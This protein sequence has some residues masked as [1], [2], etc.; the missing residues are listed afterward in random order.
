VA[1][2][3]VATETFGWMQRH[4]GN[5]FSRILSRPGYELQRVAGTREPSADELAVARA[6]LDA[7]LDLEGRSRP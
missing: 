7:V 3:G 4:R 6:A 1:A 2:I 5:I